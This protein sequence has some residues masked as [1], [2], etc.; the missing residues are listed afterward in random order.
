MKLMNIATF[1]ENTFYVKI[2]GTFKKCP[3][4]SILTKNLFQIL[5]L[6]VSKIVSS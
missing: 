4:S 3:C 5:I 2:C 1:C 6:I